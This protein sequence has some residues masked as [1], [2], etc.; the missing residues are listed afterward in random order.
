[1]EFFRCLS[2]GE[3]A[4]EDGLAVYA[5]E[6]DATTVMEDP[7]TYEEASTSLGHRRVGGRGVVLQL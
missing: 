2:S 1:M 5:L 4:L 3:W 7:G 6:F